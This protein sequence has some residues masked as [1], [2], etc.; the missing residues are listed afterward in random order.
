MSTFTASHSIATARWMTPD[1]VEGRF[2]QKTGGVWLG[3]NP[4]EDENPVGLK[5]DRHVMLV[6]GSR[7]GKG[8]SAIVPNLCHW[9]G[10]MMIVDPK[11]ENA[12]IT[13]ARRGAGTH[14]CKGLGQ[15]VY[16]LD[17]MQVAKVDSRYRAS[18]NPLDAL[19]ASSDHVNDDAVRL[20]DA[21]VEVGQGESRQ[22][23]EGA[24][25][26]VKT[27]ILH[28]LTHPRYE[29]RR[30]LITVRTLIMRGE[31]E[32]AAELRERAKA[33]GKDPDKSPSGQVV[34]WEL[35]ARNNAVHGV[36]AAAA[37][38]FLES[39][40]NSPKQ[41]NSYR[42]IAERATEFIDSKGMRD[43]LTESSF[44]LDALKTA[45]K[46]I[47]VYLSLPSAYM[48]THYRWLRMMSTLALTQ[49]ETTPGQPASGHPVMLL[50][51]E[52]AGM[53]RMD[54]IEN[55][56]AQIA[57]FGVKMFFVLQSLEQLKSVYPDRWET[58]LANCGVKIFFSSTDNFTNQYVSDM[59]GEREIVRETHG[60]STSTTDTTSTTSTTGG[61][62]A[63]QQTETHGTSQQTSKTRGGNRGWNSGDSD[64][65]NY[66]PGWFFR[67]R[68]GSNRS[69]NSGRSGGRNW[70]KSKSAGSSQS[71]AE[72]NT[73][74]DNWSRATATS[75][76]TGTTSSTNEQIF[77]KA[78]L[79][80][81]EM[82][83]LFVRVDDPNHPA[84]P[85]LALVSVAGEAPM[86][87]RRTPY[88]ADAAFVRCFDPHPDHPFVPY[89]PP[90][91]IEPPKPKPVK[92][93]E[94]PKLIV[95][96]YVQ[97][98]ETSNSAPGYGERHL[99]DRKSYIY[100]DRTYSNQAT[101]P[102]PPQA[103]WGAIT[104]GKWGWIEYWTDGFDYL[105]SEP[106]PQ[107]F[108]EGFNVKLGNDYTA[109]RYKSW[110]CPIIIG[111]GNH[112]KFLE[113]QTRNP[114][115]YSDERHPQ[116]VR[117]SLEASGGNA[118][119][120]SYTAT[121]HVTC[122]NSALANTFIGRKRMEKLKQEYQSRGQDRI[123]KTILD[124]IHGLGEIAAAQT[125][126]G[127]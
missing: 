54:I 56:V 50:L 109:E 66:G 53:K 60:A 70:S 28:V 104:G 107:K 72:G 91:K 105:T 46:G 35:A 119:R 94:P 42:M 49:M 14:I 96:T 36:I 33:K 111:K 13:A 125:R 80:K 85:G 58:F 22:W 77:K 99:F 23:D 37:D 43:C 68:T 98:G 30:N 18:F 27:L 21:L 63:F 108:S 15:D 84:Y 67:F 83:Q 44:K 19:D 64:G 95:P 87:I 75:H 73:Q 88:Y 90:Q 26:L 79:T 52:F 106:L 29:G 40:K 112:L 117:I 24:R 55:S 62:S 65:V 100:I 81:D 8:V 34:L 41:Y 10:S 7:A 25:S 47:T 1:E 118:T 102:Y 61:G 93:P 82:A 3:R 9:P 17:P 12:T 2:L 76:A 45:R 122:Y 59:L 71:M 51:D 16:V 126:K 5:D 6:A 69:H 116:T 97:P 113:V 74:S 11:G 127:Q 114:S 115:K 101:L 124:C 4:Y 121:Q 92:K 31:H 89:K 86:I 38:S 103:V 120:V 123:P 78:L 48:N 32:F 20:A 39:A 110:E 57:G